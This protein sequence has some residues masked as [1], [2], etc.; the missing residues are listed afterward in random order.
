MIR[1]Y[2]TCAHHVRISRLPTVSRISTNSDATLVLQRT[3]RRWCPRTWTGAQVE[4]NHRLAQ[5]LLQQLERLGFRAPS[6]RAVRLLDL[7]CGDCRWLPALKAAFGDNARIYAIDLNKRDLKDARAAFGKS[8]RSHLQLFEA[9]ATHLD[10]LRALPVA[11]DVVFIG[12]QQAAA[13]PDAFVSV[14]KE[15]LKRLSAA[16]TMIVTSYGMDEEQYLL[17]AVEIP[18]DVSLHRFQDADAFRYQPALTLFDVPGVFH[19]CYLL[20]QR[21]AALP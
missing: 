7:G 18:G 21:R 19:G 2:P 1:R 11:F 20:L 8:K 16:G 3:L 12:H 9:D 14:F 4:A 10:A 15:G 17:D 6:G 13:Y 5:V